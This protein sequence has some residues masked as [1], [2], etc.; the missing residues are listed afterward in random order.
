MEDSLAPQCIVVDESQVPMSGV[1]DRPCLV[2]ESLE[3]T[4]DRAGTTSAVPMTGM[5]DQPFLVDDTPAVPKVT[6]L[7]WGEGIPVQAG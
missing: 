4:E 6:N 5:K 7:C 1:K 3:N 2:V